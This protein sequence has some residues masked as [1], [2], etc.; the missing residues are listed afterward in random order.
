M[1]GDNHFLIRKLHKKKVWIA[2]WVSAKKFGSQNTNVSST[3][4]WTGE[5]LTQKK[6]VRDT[7][8]DFLIHIH[9][10]LTS[11]RATNTEYSGITCFRSY[12]IGLYSILKTE[13]EERV[14][15]ITISKNWIWCMIPAYLYF[16]S[17]F[18]RGRRRRTGQFEKT[19]N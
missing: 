19:K 2:H 12:R 6:L 10:Y 13:S 7:Y 9:F 15:F 17:T 3:N 14:S 8:N 4:C 18:S 5:R 16:R 11:Q 1:S